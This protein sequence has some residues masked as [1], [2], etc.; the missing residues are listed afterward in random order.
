[1]DPAS[2]PAGLADAFDMNKDGI[3]L[4]AVSDSPIPIEGGQA[5]AIAA[6]Y[7]SYDNTRDISPVTFSCSVPAWLKNEADARGIDCSALLQ[8]ALLDLISEDG[9]KSDD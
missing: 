1:M 8:R 9:D 6:P 5:A 7:I 4:W 3:C 2:H